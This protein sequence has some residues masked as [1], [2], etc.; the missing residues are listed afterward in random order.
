MNEI[1]SYSDYGKRGKT[2]AFTRMIE[3]INEGFAEACTFDKE[4]F[5][6][7]NITIDM[8]AKNGIMS[9][10]VSGTNKNEEIAN[11]LA[12]FVETACDGFVEVD[13]VEENRYDDGFSFEIY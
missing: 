12:D 10:I 9:I 3:K 6:H 11:Q 7:S 13:E 5:E 1:I 2:T 8:S 4:T